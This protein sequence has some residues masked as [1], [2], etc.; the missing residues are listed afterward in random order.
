MMAAAAIFNYGY[1]DFRIS[2]VIDM[3][4]IGIAIF[5]LNMMMSGHEVV[6]WRQFVEIE[7]VGRRHL[8][9]YT[10]G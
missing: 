3:L 7:D 5:T 9:N 10:S 6:K 1:F 2:D 8:E 4:Q